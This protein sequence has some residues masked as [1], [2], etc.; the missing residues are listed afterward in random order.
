IRLS[1]KFAA[2][3]GLT[4]IRPA[5][6]LNLAKDSFQ[7]HF[8]S[9][10]F[11]KINFPVP[12]IPDELFKIFP[13]KACDF[14]PDIFYHDLFLGIVR[15]NFHFKPS[16]CPFLVIYHETISLQWRNHTRAIAGSARDEFISA[17]V[18]PILKMSKVSYS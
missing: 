18:E 12:Q 2:G 8:Y 10:L 16:F 13:L 7:K 15:K 11:C 17:R 14:L 9:G 4:K 6:G 1:R 5:D 3:G